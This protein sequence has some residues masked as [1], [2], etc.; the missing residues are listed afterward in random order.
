MV[1]VGLEG[2]GQ[3]VNSE[4]SLGWMSRSIRS[5]KEAAVYELFCYGGSLQIAAHMKTD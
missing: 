2:F 3:D 1:V 5:C 4:A